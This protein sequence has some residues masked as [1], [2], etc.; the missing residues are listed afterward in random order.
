MQFFCEKK[1]SEV[2][3]CLGLRKQLNS[4]CKFGKVPKL[5]YVLKSLQ[6]FKTYFMKLNKESKKLKNTFSLYNM[7]L[8]TVNSER[9]SDLQNPF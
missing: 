2:N 8:M 5:V 7:T 9:I 1:N 3:N 4:I 6:N